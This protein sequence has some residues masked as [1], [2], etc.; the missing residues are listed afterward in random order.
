[1]HPIIRKP[2]F[3]IH[4]TQIT[5]M[6]V[7]LFILFLTFCIPAFSQPDTTTPLYKRFPSLPPVQL[8]LTDSVTKFTTEDIPKKMP[9]LVVLFSPDCEHC[10]HE[11]QE[12]VAAKESFKDI[13]VLMVSVAP[14]HQVKTFA[15]NYGLGALPNLVIAKD[16]SYFLLTY[17]GIRNF[18]FMAL[19]NKKGKLI[20]VLAGSQP[21]DK[22]IGLFKNN[23]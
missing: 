3:Q 10:Q 18:P 17:Y 9:V 5:Q 6:K 13:F 14:L 11:A 12:M 4:L 20:D 22:V 15:I 8:L 7:I 21:I 19:Y 2:H 1:M 16:P 23:K